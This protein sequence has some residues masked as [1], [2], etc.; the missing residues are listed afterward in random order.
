MRS[1]KVRFE[2]SKGQMLTGLL[3]GP[4]EGSARAYALFAHCF[5]CTKDYKSVFH[6]NRTLTERGWGVLR[7]DFTGLG[8]SGGDFAETNLGS[9]VEDFCLAAEYLERNHE[10]ARLVMGHSLGGQAALRAAHRLPSVKG[11]VTLATPSEPLELRRHFEGSLEEIE[12]RGEARVLVSGR[13]F[14]LKR[15]FFEDLDRQS[16]GDVVGTLPCALLVLHAPAD[17]VV[18]FANAERLFAAAPHPKA[19]IPLE[20]ADHLLLRE[21]DSRYAGRCIAAWASRWLPGGTD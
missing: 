4:D 6:I 10:P 21:E 15:Q 12:R 16:R 19:F 1:Q 13:P 14:T 3:D 9:N 5:T 8:E 2:G 20:G 18:P 17:E 11:V 7:F